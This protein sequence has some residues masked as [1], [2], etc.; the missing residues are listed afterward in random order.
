M[1]SPRALISAKAQV[2]VC[3]D[4]VGESTTGKNVV[5]NTVARTFTIQNCSW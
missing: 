4:V 2:F 5:L 3:S 1:A